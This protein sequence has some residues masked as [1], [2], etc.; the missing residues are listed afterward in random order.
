MEL[1]F[2]SCLISLLIKHSPAKNNFLFPIASLPVSQQ[3]LFVQ[4]TCKNDIY[5]LFLSAVDDILKKGL[6][7]CVIFKILT[8]SKLSEGLMG[9]KLGQFGDL[10]KAD[11]LK[12]GYILVNVRLIL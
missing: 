10:H 4:L 5:F 1:W 11:D 6:H 8:N 12:N 3:G 9:V 7:N 2:C